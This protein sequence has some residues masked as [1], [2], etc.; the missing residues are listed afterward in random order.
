MLR[1]SELLER[2]RPAGTPG[3]PTEGAQQHLRDLQDRE[4]ADINVLL[5]EFEAEADQALAAAHEEAAR[6]RSEGERQAH[7]LRAGLPDR[8]AVAQAAAAQRST[9][10][11]G[12]E[13][14]EVVDNADRA[15]AQIRS[16]STDRMP[17]LVDAVVAMIWSA[18]SSRTGTSG[19]APGSEQGGRR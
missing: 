19:T 18:T 14:E 12:A 6:L 13:L 2:I 16:Q 11:S 5:R 3:A 15:V 4:I 10:R 8:V 17:A 9:H 7:R 1:L